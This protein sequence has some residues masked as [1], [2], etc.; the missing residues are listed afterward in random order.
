MLKDELIS[1]NSCSMFVYLLLNQIQILFAI[2]IATNKFDICFSMVT[3]T[4][5]NITPPQ[6]I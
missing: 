2:H 1:C 5:P 6:P 4:G 3:Y